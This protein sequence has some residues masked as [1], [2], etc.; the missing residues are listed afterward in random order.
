[1]PELLDVASHN[2]RQN[3]EE[4]WLPMTSL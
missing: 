3:M 2:M 1:M 4:D